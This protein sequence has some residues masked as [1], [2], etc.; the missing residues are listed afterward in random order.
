MMLLLRDLGRGLAELRPLVGRIKGIRGD[1]LR[2]WLL[3]WRV[4]GPSCPDIRLGR[5]LTVL[6][7]SAGVG[8]GHWR[9][10]AWLRVIET[11]CRA[12]LMI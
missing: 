7:L 9:S 11:G 6:V 10:A 2:I 1:G 12:L 3:W 4:R 8:R 5:E